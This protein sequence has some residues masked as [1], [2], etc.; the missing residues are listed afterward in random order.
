MKCGMELPIYS[1]T[2]TVSLSKFANGYIPQRSTHWS[3]VTPSDGMEYGQHGFSSW[4]VAWWNQAITSTNVDLLSI[5]CIGME[6]ISVKSQVKWNNFHGRKHNR[7][8][9]PAKCRPFCACLSVLLLMREISICWEAV[10]VTEKLS[11]FIRH[12]S[13]GL[14]I[15]YSKLWNL[16][17]DIWV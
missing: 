4:L 3:Q 17:S 9:C 13:D 5:R 7:K 10:S 12:L 8:V 14:Y 11:W 2:S 15:F 1:Q 16:S 6:Q